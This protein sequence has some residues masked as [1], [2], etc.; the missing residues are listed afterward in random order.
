MSIWR[1]WAA[2]VADVAV[3]AAFLLVTSRTW[4]YLFPSRTNAPELCKAQLLELWTRVLAARAVMQR[5]SA[6]E[7]ARWEDDGGA[8]AQV[9]E[10]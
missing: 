7:I 2:W 10:K 8:L 6:T 4:L 9:Y 3:G 1:R 5:E